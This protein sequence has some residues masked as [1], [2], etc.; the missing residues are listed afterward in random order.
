MPKHDLEDK[1]AATPVQKAAKTD[2]DEAPAA[3]ESVPKKAP[4]QRMAVLF[5]Y[6]GTGYKGSQINPGQPTI[7]KELMDALVKAGA[8]GLNRC[9]RTDK[10]VHAAGNVISAKLLA[11]DGLVDKV[12][13]CLPPQVRIYDAFQVN[14]SFNAKNH[15]GGRQYE[16]SLP[17]YI[18]KQ[19]VHHLYPHSALP[20]ESV[21]HSE[22]SS[23]VGAPWVLVESYQD[24]CTFRLDKEAL[25]H[26]R[27][28]LKQYEG[29][30]NF[31]NFT[32]GC[33]FKE[34]NAGRYITSFVACDPY[35]RADGVEWVKLRVNGQS[36]M[37]HQIRKMV[38]LAVMMVRTKTPSKLVPTTFKE[39][40]INI[41]KAP[42]L[43]LLL[44]KPT[45]DAFNKQQ[46]MQHEG[47]KSLEFD[48]YPDLVNPFVEEWINKDMYN[49][50]AEKQ[51]FKN[52]TFHVDEHSLNYAWWLTKEG[53]IRID[54]KPEDVSAED[55]DDEGQKKEED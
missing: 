14:S 28:C 48:N 49:E 20:V 29:T 51:V 32:V 50:E 54:L 46:N 5:G 21:P 2:A 15:C 44:R 18:L 3:N 9:A 1:E 23:T 33:K 25:E 42:A 17:T 40:K 13:A 4:K 26:L 24:L 47:R 12:N 52:W 27:D 41:P 53:E 34:K 19:S 7:E 36:F 31:H 6:C 39:E 37:L 10:G 30:H 22:E 11:I 43:G 16:Y 45:F 38:G 55:V 8:V 35:V